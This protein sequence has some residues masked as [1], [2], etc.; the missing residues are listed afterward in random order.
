MPE[1]PSL[2]DP[3][4]LVLALIASNQG[5]IEGR[6]VLQ[7]LSYFIGEH[8]HLSLGFKPHYFG[9]FSSEIEDSTEILVCSGLLRELSETVPIHDPNSDFEP[10]KY[11]YDLTEK[12]KQY[13]R[14]SGLEELK[15]FQAAKDFLN[16]M[17][18]SMGFNPRVL[19]AV[20]KIHY[21]VSAEASRSRLRRLEPRPSTLVG[22]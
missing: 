6:T 1:S 18:G 12:G 15:D 16:S 19:S 22:N 4:L 5:H 2:E 3:K 21:I 13:L 10:R 20:A 17:R 8:L 9:P 7:K 11:R 14:N